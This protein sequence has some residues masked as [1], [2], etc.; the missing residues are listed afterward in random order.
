MTVSNSRACSTSFNQVLWGDLP[1]EIKVSFINTI[2]ASMEQYTSEF[3]DSNVKLVH[4]GGNS[5]ASMLP[6][7]YLEE[8]ITVTK[9][10]DASFLENDDFNAHYQLPFL[11]SRLK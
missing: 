11:E 7:G 1:D 2:G 8:D 3:N 4:D 9:P 10:L 5:I 6:E